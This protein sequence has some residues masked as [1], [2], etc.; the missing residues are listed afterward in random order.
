MG[1]R[2]ETAGGVP[3]NIT[4]ATSLAPGGRNEKTTAVVGSDS[5]F[6][7]YNFG[8]GYSV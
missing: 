1:H 2:L 7:M 6:A 4:I 8:G 3:E 5:Y